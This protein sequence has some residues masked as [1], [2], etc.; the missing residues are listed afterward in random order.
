M[1]VIKELSRRIRKAKDRGRK[2]RI[3]KPTRIRDPRLLERT[4][5]RDLRI[6]SQEFSKLVE[7]RLIPRLPQLVKQRDYHAPKVRLHSWSS[8]VA[9]LMESIFATWEDRFGGEKARTTALKQALAVN[10]Y[11][12]REVMRSLS[13]MLGFDVTL[14][15]PWLEDKIQTFT[16]ENVQLI[17]SIGQD[18]HDDVKELVLREI[19]AGTR[20]EEIQDMI[21]ERFDV[22]E[23]RAN[24]IGR[25]QTN[26]YHGDL[27]RS[28]QVEA[29]INKYR[30]RGVMDE[31]ERD[32]HVEKEGEVYSWDDPPADTGH[33]GEDYQCR[34][35]AEPIIDLSDVEDDSDAA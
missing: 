27:N 14:D 9:S 10:A 6:L 28:R 4:Y 5:Q 8:D 34:C 18:Q 11:N 32:S 22:S 12:R 3:R 2:Y 20:V 35:W 17:T 23:S 30:W 25:D 13:R 24:L 33:P 26:K 19:N 1:N 7:E 21:R 29:G 15:E 31:R 16:E